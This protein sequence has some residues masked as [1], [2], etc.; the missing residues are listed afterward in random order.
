MC[1]ADTHLGF[2]SIEGR[3]PY[4]K[5]IAILNSRHTLHQ[6]AT[7]WLECC[8]ASWDQRKLRRIS[9]RA[10]NAVK[11]GQPPPSGDILCG[12]GLCSQH[13]C[14]QHWCSQHWCSQQQPPFCYFA[15][16]GYPLVEGAA[17]PCVLQ[18]CILTSRRRM[19]C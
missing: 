2:N 15:H 8:S 18:G 11:W 19:L 3:F 12:L 1:P 16:R 6:P 10:A 14:S 9:C 17:R 5:Q 7:A 13:W 4:P